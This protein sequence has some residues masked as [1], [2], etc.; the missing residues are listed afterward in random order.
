LPYRLPQGTI[1]KERSIARLFSMP[2]CKGFT[3]FSFTFEQHNRTAFLLQGSHTAVACFECHKK[4]DKWNFREIGIKC[5]DC[6][7]DIHKTYL[8]EK[9]YPEFNCAVCHKEARW[10]DIT[11]DHSKTGFSLTGVHSAQKC[12]IC[13]FP[14]DQTGLLYRSLQD[15][16][17]S[18]PRAIPT[19]TT[20]SLK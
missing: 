5:K 15:Y 6:H 16:P 7:P 20:G 10:S 8:Q 19:D 17:E 18:V 11:F 13:H 1:C 2:F 12:R 3:L 14:K 9:Y 4:Q